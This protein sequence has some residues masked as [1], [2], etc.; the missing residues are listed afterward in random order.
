ML[1]Q[2]LGWLGLAATL[3]IALPGITLAA[4]PLQIRICPTL[5]KTEQ[6]LQ[7]HGNLMPDGCQI[8]TVTR[9]NSSAGSICQVDLSQNDQGALNTLRNAVSTTHWWTA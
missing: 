8:A 9:V 2:R 6:I 7:S 1:V 3:L 4:D 5:D